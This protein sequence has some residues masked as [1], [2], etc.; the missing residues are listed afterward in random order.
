MLDEPRELLARAELPFIPPL[1]IPRDPPPPDVLRALNISDADAASISFHRSVGCD[2]CN[3]TGYRGRI[4]IYEVMKI[5][6]TQRRLIAARATEDQIRDAAIAGGMVT[7]GEDG[8][9]KVK[10]GITTPEELL[11]VETPPM[12]DWLEGFVPMKMHALI[13]FGRWP[14]IIAEPLPGDQDLYCVTTAMTHY[15]KGVALAATGDLAGAGE[16]RRLFQA[17]VG[18]GYRDQDFLSLF[19]VEAEAAGMAIKPE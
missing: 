18:R 12:A 7:L 3:H 16:Q 1:L 14:D 10:S 19:A 17:A 5:T 9:A 11:R 4:G 2:Q 13:R 6:D 8:L 15:A